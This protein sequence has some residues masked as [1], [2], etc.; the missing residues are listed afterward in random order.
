MGVQC[1]NLVLCGVIIG[2]FV[3]QDCKFVIF[4]VCC[5]LYVWDVIDLLCNFV[6][7]LIIDCVIIL[8]VE[9]FEVIEIDENDVDFVVIGL[10]CLQIIYEG[11]VVY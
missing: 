9:W 5:Y 7:Y 10:E 8:I 4:K 1:F 3:E 2:L 11:V 6:Q